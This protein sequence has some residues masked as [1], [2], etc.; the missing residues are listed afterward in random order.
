[1]NTIGEK[2]INQILTKRLQGKVATTFTGSH[3]LKRI[4]EF[5][6]KI[7]RKKLLESFNL[8]NNKIKKIVVLAPHAFS[9][10]S[11]NDGIIFFK[12]YFSHYKETLK[13]I[14]KLNKMD[15]LWLIKPHPSSNLYGEN[16][17]AE[18]V[19]QKYKSKNIK[20]CPKMNNINLINICDH[21]ITCTGRIALEFA[22]NGKKSIMGGINEISK[23]NIFENSKNKDQYFNKIKNISNLKTLNKKQKL[24]AKKILYYLDN[25]KPEI[26]LSGS[27][28]LTDK[29][30][31]EYIH[32][33]ENYLK[34]LNKK[35]KNKS[36]YE[37]DFFRNLTKH[38]SQNIKY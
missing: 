11:H 9:D 13:F 16:G 6:I 15:I 34:E 26:F 27:K 29:I 33:K 23:F 12:D 4:K 22:C 2:K 28:I 35:L 7:T 30:I 5:K 20:L 18:S 19:L 25:F 37:D 14:Y 36:F 38:F 24:N 32:N 3:D 8:Q 31:N 1:M 17:I 10:T 21:A